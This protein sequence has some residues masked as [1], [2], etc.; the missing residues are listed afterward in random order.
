[1]GEAT[2]DT[3]VTHYQRPGLH[4]LLSVWC[5]M[6][7]FADITPFPRLVT[8]KACLRVAYN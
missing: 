7:D 2:A 8:C 4:G 3:D 1:M 5:G 6:E